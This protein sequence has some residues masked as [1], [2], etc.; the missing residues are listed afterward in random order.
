MKPGMLKKRAFVYDE[1][2]DCYLCPENQILSYRT[3]SREGQRE[4]KSDPSVCRTCPLLSQ[5]TQSRNQTKVITRHVW[6]KYKEAVVEHRYARLRGR[7]NVREQCLL[8]GH[9]AEPQKDG[10]VPLRRRFFAH[11]ERWK[12]RKRPTPSPRLTVGSMI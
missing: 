8:A 5:C 12:P 1:H 7:D 10:P 2:Y 6:G 4:Y 11:L 9:R 3:T